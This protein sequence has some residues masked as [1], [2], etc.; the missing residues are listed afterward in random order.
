MRKHVKTSVNSSSLLLCLLLRQRIGLVQYTHSS[1][2]TF[3][4]AIALNIEMVLNGVKL[5]VF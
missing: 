4:A 3:A 2:R 1:V 5:G